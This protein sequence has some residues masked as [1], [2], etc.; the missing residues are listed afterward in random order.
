M[1][2]KEILATIASKREDVRSLNEEIDLLDEQLGRFAP[3][4]AGDVV[5]TGR[6]QIFQIVRVIAKSSS[7]NATR[8][9]LEYR[10]NLK[11]KSGE[12]SD[13]ERK[14]YSWDKLKLASEK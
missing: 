1:T 4:Q 3:F 14:L 8:F 12:F 2:A 6:S 7:W 11:L 10:A 5:S 13:S 9:E